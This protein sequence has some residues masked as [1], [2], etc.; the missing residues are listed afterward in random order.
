V[1]AADVPHLWIGNPDEVGAYSAG[2]VVPERGSSYLT[3]R[4]VK[5]WF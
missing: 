1:I 5:D 2:L 3:W 4:E